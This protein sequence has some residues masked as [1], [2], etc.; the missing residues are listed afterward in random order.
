MHFCTA[1]IA[2]GEEIGNTVVRDH[3]SPVSWPEIEVIRAIHGDASVNEV[4]PFVSVPQS[5]RA[6]RRRLDEL[7]G[8]T[9]CASVWGGNSVPPEMEAPAATLRDGITWMNPITHETETTGY[10]GSEEVPEA[11]PFPPDDPMPVEEPK[12]A[13]KR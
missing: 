13:R 2:L 9:A 11:S 5:P 6:E 10:P 4:S 8:P 3:F 1:V 12:V 7:Y